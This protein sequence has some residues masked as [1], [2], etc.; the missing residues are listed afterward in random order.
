MKLTI[1]TKLIEKII[2]IWES[3]TDINQYR[4]TCETK[5]EENEMYKKVVEKLKNQEDD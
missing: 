2:D 5:K 3:V 4:D 1:N